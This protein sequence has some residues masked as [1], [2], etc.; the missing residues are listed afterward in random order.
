MECG[1]PI[2]PGVS[3]DVTGSSSWQQGRRG[4]VSHLQFRDRARISLPLVYPA[5]SLFDHA[6]H[7]NPHRP[8]LQEL[9]LRANPHRLD[10]R[11]NRLEVTASCAGDARGKGTCSVLSLTLCLV[12]PLTSFATS[13][14]HCGRPSFC[15]R[16]RISCAEFRL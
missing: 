10:I 8:T 9:Y 15:S 2:N 13:S 1:S 12:H 16:A 4:R 5:H 14:S 3:H 6:R 11:G 7:F